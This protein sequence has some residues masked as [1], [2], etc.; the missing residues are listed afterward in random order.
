MLLSPGKD[1]VHSQMNL[2]DN[3]VWPSVVYVYISSRVQYLCLKIKM[4]RAVYVY[5]YC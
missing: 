4:V 2:L 1:L 5:T 3:M